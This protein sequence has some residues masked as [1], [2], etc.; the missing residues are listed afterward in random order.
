MDHKKT[1]GYDFIN[2]NKYTL[3]I[4]NEPIKQYIP[5]FKINQNNGFKPQYKPGKGRNKRSNR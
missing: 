5:V 3:F 1:D 2:F 4:P